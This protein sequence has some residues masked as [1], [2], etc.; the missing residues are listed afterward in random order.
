MTYGIVD[1]SLDGDEDLEALR[2]HDEGC[3]VCIL[4][5]KR[6]VYTV[7]MVLLQKVFKHLTISA[8]DEA[9]RQHL[10]NTE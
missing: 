9:P 1:Y 2:R 3:G 8:V 10:A 4:V 6:A 5:G 7:C